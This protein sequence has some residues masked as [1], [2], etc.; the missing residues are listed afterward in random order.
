MY[1][2]QPSSASVP[3]GTHRPKQGTLLLVQL[4]RTSKI[5]IT[6][7]ELRSTHFIRLRT[8]VLQNVKTVPNVNHVDQSLVDNGI[9]PHHDFALK[10]RA[11]KL[12]RRRIQKVGYGYSWPLAQTRILRGDH[13]QRRWPE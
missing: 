13:R 3:D 8:G 6:L 9:A 12:A 5:G 7:Q 2:S 1:N 10:I 11:R 4:N